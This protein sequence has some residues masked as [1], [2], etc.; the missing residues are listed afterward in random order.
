[1]SGWL[2]VQLH[3]VVVPNSP[4]AGVVCMT[5]ATA[6]PGCDTSPLLSSVRGEGLLNKG[7]RPAS[8][9][10]LLSAARGGIKAR[11]AEQ[12]ALTTQGHCARSKPTGPRHRPHQASAHRDST[13]ADAV[14]RGPVGRSFR[15]AGELDLVG[16]DRR[17]R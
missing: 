14:R 10:P 8:L 4:A 12:S 5:H 13:T 15:C 1:L 16:Q 9:E 2:L 11:R 6:G 3:M 17:A 7:P